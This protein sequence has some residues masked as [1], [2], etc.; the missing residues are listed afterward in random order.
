MSE[1]WLTKR[2]LALRLKVSTRTIERLQLPF[3]R[4]GGQNRYLESQ[5][6]AALAGPDDLPDNVVPLRP[7]REEVVA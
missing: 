5:A 2:E 1:A 4:V 3:T 6:V 7:H